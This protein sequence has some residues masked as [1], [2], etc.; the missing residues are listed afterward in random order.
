MLRLGTIVLGADDAERAAAFW[1]GALGFEI[2]PFPAEEDGF[3]MVVPPDRV[4][5]RV[6]VHRSSVP[7]QEEPRVHLDLVVDTAAEQAAEV[8]RLVGLGATRVAWEYP[9]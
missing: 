8:E 1:A 9:A 3:T 5:T 2:V 4:G 6:A 7:V